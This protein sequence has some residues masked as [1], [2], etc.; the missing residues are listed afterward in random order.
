VKLSVGNSLEYVL[1]RYEEGKGSN[2]TYACELDAYVAIAAANVDDCTVTERGP[3]V[4]IAEKNGGVVDYGTTVSI[5][6]MQKAS[7]S[8]DVLRVQAVIA[9]E[10]RRPFPGFFS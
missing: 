9:F 8:C 3:G 6:P 5:V 4:V 1:V 10:N 7:G 2:W